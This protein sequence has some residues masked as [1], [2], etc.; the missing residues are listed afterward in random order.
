[1]HLDALVA[2]GGVALFGLM[3]VAG[4]FLSEDSDMKMPDSSPSTKEKKKELVIAEIA[5][6]EERL[7]TVSSQVSGL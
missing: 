4:S 5:D 1:M 6:V 2:F 7:H 3:S